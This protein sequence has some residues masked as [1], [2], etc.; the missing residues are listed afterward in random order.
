[1]SKDQKTSA[2]EKSAE[3]RAIILETKRKGRLPVLLVCGLAILVLTGAAVFV[4][5]NNDEDT[6]T[7]RSFKSDASATS[8]TYPLELFADGKARHFRYKGDDAI[9]IRY[10]ILK[11]SDGVIRAAFDACDVCWPAGKGYEQSGDVMVCRNCGRKFASVMV[12]EVKGGCNPAPLNREVKEGKVVLQIN[13]IL[14]G[15][16]YFD[17]SKRG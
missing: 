10:F 5:S 12:N 11:S 16:Q 6:A 3:K 15:K 17:F 4:S 9:T 2:Q 1:M 7:S 13:D 14:S 8:I